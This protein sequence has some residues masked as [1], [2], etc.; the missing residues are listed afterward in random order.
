MIPS[1]VFVTLTNLYVDGFVHVSRL[2]HE[3]YVYDEQ[4]SSFIG[5]DTGR[6]FRVGGELKVTV[7]D[8]DVEARKVDFRCV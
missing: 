1:G 7:V 6:T 8:V 3:F 4:K 2:G 5:E